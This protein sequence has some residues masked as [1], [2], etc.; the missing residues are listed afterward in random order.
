MKNYV[1]IVAGGSGKRIGGETP[2]QFLPLNGIPVL[3]HAINAFWESK[4]KPEIHLALPA[5]L[6]NYWIGLCREYNFNIPHQLIAGGEERYHSVKNALNKLAGGGFVA[7]HDG[8]RPVVTSDLIDRCYEQALYLGNAVPAV[9]ANDSIRESIKSQKS[10]PLNR[11]EI[12]LVQ[13]PQVFNLKQLR[14][15]YE[16]EFDEIFTDDAS[17]MEH[18]GNQIFLIE[19]ERTNIKITFPQDIEIAE[20]LIKRKP[21]F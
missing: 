6:H 3:M 9:A 13:T 10:K 4:T 2:K 17:V 5:L 12:F 7:V 1:I 20:L 11:N 8:V 21:T 16:Q 19:G 18:N 15:A 14:E